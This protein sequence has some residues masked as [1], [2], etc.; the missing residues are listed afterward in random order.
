MGSLGVLVLCFKTP[1]SGRADCLLRAD[2]GLDS[3]FGADAPRH[4][5][6]TTAGGDVEALRLAALGP[7]FCHFWQDLLLLYLWPFFALIPQNHQGNLQD[8]CM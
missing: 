4:Q 6:L 1:K 5:T 3:S 8:T 7:F 2:F